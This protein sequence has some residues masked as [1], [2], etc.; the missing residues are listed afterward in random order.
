MPV[1]CSC[2]SRNIRPLAVD[3]CKS[4]AG[5]PPNESTC[6]RLEL[7]FERHDCSRLLFFTRRKQCATT[8]PALIPCRI[9]RRAPFDATCANS[10][11]TG[12]GQSA[13]TCMPRSFTS[14]ASAIVK[15]NTYAFVAP[16]TAKFPS[17]KKAARLAV[18]MIAEPLFI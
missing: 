11:L 9:S 15:L 16:Y 12:P 4:C 6:K 18:F 3:V 13:H 10:V 7:P 5:I 2:C 1:D 17:G 14:A 8:L